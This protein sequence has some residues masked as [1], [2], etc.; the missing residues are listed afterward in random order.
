MHQT[1]STR[2]ECSEGESFM[3][4]ELLQNLFD[5]LPSLKGKT[6]K[7]LRF[8]EDSK[9]GMMYT[10][11]EIKL[12][13]SELMDK[14]LEEIQ[15]EYI[16]G[17]QKRL[18]QYTAV[19]RYDGSMVGTTI[20]SLLCT[21]SLIKAAYERMVTSL[22]NPQT[23]VDPLDFNAKAYVLHGD[24]NYENTV[25]PV[26]LI[27]VMNPF[28]KLKHKFFYDGGTF[29]EISENV[30]DLRLY[31]DV[32]LIGEE[33]FFLGMAGEKL[34]GM[35]RAY[36]TNVKKLAAEFGKA[37]FLVHADRLQETAL[38]GHYPRMLVA[39]QPDKMK[40]LKN[41]SQ[42]QT[43]AEKFGI[44]ISKDGTLD[45]DKPGNAAKLLRFLCNKGMLDPTDQSAMEV[46]GAKRWAP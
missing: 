31:A 21:D 3:S 22:A 20:Y 28:K 32:I 33:T 43:I 45:M 17:K 29:K 34:F 5:Q 6:L 26:K 2:L 23:E 4:I 14:L 30:L 35:E 1:Y 38:S 46:E 8:E 27:A 44:E 11:R 24:W 18:E 42:R 40:Y 39:Y 7:L 41:K 12:Y 13:P 16:S 37:S 36:R 15:A 9:N 19:E 25:L 10:S